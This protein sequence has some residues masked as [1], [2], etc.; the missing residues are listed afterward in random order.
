[1]RDPDDP[2]AIGDPAASFRDPEDIVRH[3]GLS[4]EQKRA[5]LERWRGT[6]GDESVLTRIGRALAL[7]DTESGG[8]QQTHEGVLHGPGAAPTPREGR[9][10]RQA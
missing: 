2:R 8:R 10:E 9:G 6:G 3:A 5:L 7:L 4:L 1:M